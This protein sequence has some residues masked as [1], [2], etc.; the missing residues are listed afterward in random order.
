MGNAIDA[1]SVSDIRARYAHYGETEK[2]NK[3]T[4]VWHIRLLLEEIDRLEKGRK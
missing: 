3:N 2:L 4:A 1:V